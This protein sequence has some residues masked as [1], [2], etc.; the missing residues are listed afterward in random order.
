[1]KMH[2][3]NCNKDMGKIKDEFH[4]FKIDA[5][6]CNGCGEIIYD[7]KDIQPILRYNKLKENKK[8]LTVTVGVLGKSKIFRIPKIAEEI[9]DINKGEKLKFDLKPDEMTI[10]FK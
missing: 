2:C 3:Y 7:E 8:L 6:K 1:M 9:Y 10:K 5:W 4:G